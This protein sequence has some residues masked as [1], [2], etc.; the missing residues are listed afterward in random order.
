MEWGRRGSGLGQGFG[1]EGEFTDDG[2][3]GGA[4]D[5]DGASPMKLQDAQYLS[6]YIP[7]KVASAGVSSVYSNE[8]FCATERRPFM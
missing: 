4:E 8:L 1:G 7:K 3:G 2:S 5:G 6:L